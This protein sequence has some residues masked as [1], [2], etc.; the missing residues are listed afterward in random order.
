VPELVLVEAAP[1]QAVIETQ[2]LS[3]WAAELH[4]RLDSGSDPDPEASRRLASWLRV[5]AVGRDTITVTEPRVAAYSALWASA[6]NA[7]GISTRLI[8]AAGE[9]CEPT[10]AGQV[11]AGPAAM[12][13]VLD[14]R[15]RTRLQTWA[16]DRAESAGRAV[17]RAIQR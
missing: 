1:D 8:N 12:S 15:W 4:D 2:A 11:A 3:R 7:V 16:L 5:Q 10:P 14:D 9:S 17:V 13:G 6:A